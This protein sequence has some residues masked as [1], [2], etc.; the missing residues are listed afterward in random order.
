MKVAL[1]I[2]PT[3]N[4]SGTRGIGTYTSNLLHNLKKFK[5][6]EVIEFRGKTIPS[7]DV[8]HYP[9][10]DLFFHTLPI[11]KTNRRVVTIHDVI[12]LIFPKQFPPGVKGRINLQL[13]KLALKNT[14]AVI[15]D[16]KSSKK[17]ISK[18]LS[19]PEKKIHVV[20]LAASKDYKPSSDEE[21][22]KVKKKFNLP[23]EYFLYVGDVNWNKNVL[24][25]LDG[26]KRTSVNLVMVGNALTDRHLQQT[27]VIENKIRN[28]KIGEHITKLGFIT[29]NDLAS[30]YS[31][32]K[33]T[34]VPSH[35]EG[36][37]LP[38]L[39]SMSCSTPVICAKNSSLLEIGGD[40]VIYFDSND[41]LSLEYAINKI[42]HME[43]DELNILKRN[44]LKQ[45]SK[46]SWEK[47][48]KET[49][50]IYDSIKK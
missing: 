42:I 45:A 50:K 18:K 38:V 7:S 48:A 36:F 28:L 29:N 43:A 26:V 47:T 13:Q 31:L 19:Y 12:P 35:Y 3:L 22:N 33:A 24:G 4:Q 14:D 20:Y 46:F 30:I 32:A 40:T 8:T 11:N 16:S 1:D 49:I 34:I 6:T 15:C 25:L 41:T 21:K 9:Y 5:N 23:D 27:Q 37:G 10:F 44:S 17:D 39:E 2:S